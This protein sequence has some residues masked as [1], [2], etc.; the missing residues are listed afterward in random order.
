MLA[1]L[2]VPRELF[3]DPPFER[4]AQPRWDKLILSIAVGGAELSNCR[5]SFV[6]FAIPVFAHPRKR[7]GQ[8]QFMLCFQH[9]VEPLDRGVPKAQH[10]RTL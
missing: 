5:E 9:V 4:P 7:Q 6:E 1:L 10:Q 2:H 3:R 8:S